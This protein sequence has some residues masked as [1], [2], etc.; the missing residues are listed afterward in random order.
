M[1]EEGGQSGGEVYGREGR[2]ARR[3]RE[4]DGRCSELSQGLR[5]PLPCACNCNCNTPKRERPGAT[6]ELR[7]Y[8]HTARPD[9]ER[10]PP[11]KAPERIAEERRTGAELKFISMLLARYE[12]AR[13]GER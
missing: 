6:R 7:I 2:E 11:A 9:K 5:V 12:R 4:T 1:D 8:T 3:E 13:E 10:R